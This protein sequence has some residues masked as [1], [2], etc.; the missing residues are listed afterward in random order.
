MKHYLLL[1]MVE[2]GIRGGSYPAVHWYAKA[3]NQYMKNFDKNINSSYL[4]FLNGNSLYGYTMSQKMPV[5]GFKQKKC[6]Y[7]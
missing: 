4:K 3:S 5:N 1:M 2:K 7:I 6:I